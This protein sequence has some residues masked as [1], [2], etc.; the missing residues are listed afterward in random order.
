MMRHGLLIVALAT[1]PWP[2]LAQNEPFRVVNGTSLPATALHVVR[3]GQDGWGAN[4]LT[5]GSLAPGAVLSM[6]PPESAGCTFDIRLLL[7]GG[8][9]AI[10]RD[11]D[12][13]QERS[14]V[15][16]AAPVPAVAAPAPRPPGGDAIAPARPDGA[17]D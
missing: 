8:R 11:A 7:E 1:L 9:E 15:V 12:V 13:C 5:R 17:R 2:A 16:S 3:S 6:R 14:I 10:R 4:L